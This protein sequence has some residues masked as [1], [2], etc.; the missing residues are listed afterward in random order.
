MSLSLFGTFATEP[1]T[2]KTFITHGSGFEDRVTRSMS[3]K[4]KTAAGQ[5]DQLRRED[6]HIQLN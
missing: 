4:K 3:P 6:C 2:G 1:H 5:V